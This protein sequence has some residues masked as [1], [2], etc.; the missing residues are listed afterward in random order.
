MTAT[1]QGRSDRSVRASRRLET[2][3]A[4][5]RAGLLG[6][7]PGA[8]LSAR[9]SDAV[10]ALVVDM[11]RAMLE[12]AQTRFGALGLGA[13]GALGRRELGPYSDVDLV[14]LSPA[15]R[16]GE[17]EF[18]AFVRD[19][20]HPLWDA[21][22][23]A[24]VSVHDPQTWLAQ[25]QDDLTLCT[26]L[27][28]VRLLVGHAPVFDALR[29][30]AFERFFG[31]QRLP[32]LERLRNEVTER[33]QRYGGTVFLV[34]PDLKYGP[35]GLRDLAVVQWCLLATHGSMDLEQLVR[36]EQVR[37]R[38]A[39][40]I[41]SSRDSLLRLR[42]ALHVAAERTQDRLVF[43]YQ[44]LLPPVLGLVGVGPIP[45][46]ELVRAVETAMQEYYRAARDLLRYGRRLCERCRPE[47][48][49]SKA[50]S[51][52]LDER[53]AIV[54]GR[55][56]HD[57]ADSFVDTPVLALEALALA[58]DHGVELSGTTFDAIAEAAGMPSAD[59]MAGEPEAQRR[60]LDLLCSVDDMGTPTVLELCNELRLLERVVPEFGPIRGRMQHDSY[61]VYTVDQHTM[62]AIH[63]LKR[64]AR[65]EY[66]KDYPLATA[67]HLQ[68][69]DPRVL[70][71]ATLVHDTGKAEEGDQCETG[72]VIAREVASRAGLSPAEVERC[73]LLV[74]EHLTMPLLS[75][76]RDLSDPLLIEEFANTLGA[77]SALEEL[78][79][80]SLVDTAQVR[81]GNLTSWKLT[82]LD[83]LYLLTSAYL[84]RG[85]LVGKQRTKRVGEPI[86][87]PDRY[88]AL[89][90]L[91]MRRKHAELVERL[92]GDDRAAVLEL[93][94]GS[95]ALRLTL[96]ARDRPGLLAQAA[97]ILDDHGVDIMASDI[98]SAPGPP[99][100]VVDVF[101]IEAKEGPE[102]GLDVETVTAIEQA[103]QRPLDRTML[104]TP[105]PTRPAVSW[106]WAPRVPTR[107]DFDADPAGERSI[108][109]IET[110]TG[111]EVLRRI[112]LAFA[113]EGVEVLLAR[114]NTEADRAANVFYVPHLEPEA[115]RRLAERLEAYLERT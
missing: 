12:D 34:E 19:L 6:E 74:R 109:E 102:H 80:L 68:L 32:F 104:E 108:V 8:Q 45:D 2:A 101:R 41:S 50:E 93:E 38:M 61:H 90:H 84:R 21:G 43:Q 100:V 55:L 46:A 86:G 105:P 44:E 94:Q 72:A 59:E 92:I 69:D 88:Y 5:L 47:A 64:I 10:E 77:G 3:R 7:T 36:E 37:P 66:N 53:F 113:A 110:A 30:E 33:H 16:D 58:R 26:A 15:A 29:E 91:E 78:Y 99:A 35:G 27:L 83:E 67:L 28:D 22:L 11:S 103:L 62:R 89:Y 112:T 107:I 65:G 48:P 87:M 23:R 54:G 20:V 114:C 79:L 60:V 13:V 96:V 18:D 111:A 52:R 40:L 49:A 4:E 1:E 9:Y 73:A 76:K 56:V 81:P 14:L 25:A 85:R 24:N 115:Q 71:L 70:Y 51:R 63:M 97:A 57:A 106:R 31:E 17:P 39:G 82:L 75:Q 98:F 42:A 95:G